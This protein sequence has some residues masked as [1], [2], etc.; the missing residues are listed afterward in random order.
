[1]KVLIAF[2]LGVLSTLAASHYMR[3]SAA[4]HEVMEGRVWKNGR[5]YDRKAK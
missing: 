4:V 3:A 1:M 2:S 5:V